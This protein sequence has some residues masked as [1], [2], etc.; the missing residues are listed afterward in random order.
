M[1]GVANFFTRAAILC[2]LLGIVALAVGA[3]QSAAGASVAYLSGDGLAAATALC[4]L[5]VVVGSGLH[6]ILDEQKALRRALTGEPRAEPMPLPFGM[7][8]C[9]KCGAARPRNSARCGGCG[10]EGW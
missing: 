1:R 7:R 4:A 10:H 6:A 9:P 5:I 8:E 2:T 3:L